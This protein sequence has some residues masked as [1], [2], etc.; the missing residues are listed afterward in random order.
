MSPLPSIL[1]ASQQEAAAEPQNERSGLEE[2][3]YAGHLSKAAAVAPIL[4]Y[5]CPLTLL[6]PQVTRLKYCR[7]LITSARPY[8]THLQ[9]LPS[10]RHPLI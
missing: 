1:G 9:R 5:P 7:L 10:T 4:Q 8:H 3:R 6:V 2:V